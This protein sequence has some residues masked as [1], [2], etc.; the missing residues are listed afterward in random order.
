MTNTCATGTLSCATWNVLFLD[1]STGQSTV[2]AD[3]PSEGQVFNWAFGDALEAYYVVRCDYPPDR[4]ITF[5]DVT[6]SESSPRSRSRV[7][8]WSWLRDFAALRIRSIGRISSG[9]FTL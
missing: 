1:L 6:L 5:E 8:Q 9:H 3:T 2:L 4:S 7:E